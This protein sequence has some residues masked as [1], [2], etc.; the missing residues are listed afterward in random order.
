[1]KTAR[2]FQDNFVVLE[3]YRMVD[4]VLKTAVQRARFEPDDDVEYDP[5]LRPRQLRLLRWMSLDLQ[6][7]DLARMA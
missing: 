7:R 5:E 2:Q 6:F 3:E 4:P 1:V